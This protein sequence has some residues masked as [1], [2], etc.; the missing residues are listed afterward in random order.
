[1]LPSFKADGGKVGNGDAAEI[2]ILHGVVLK[3]RGIYL[4]L[5]ASFFPLLFINY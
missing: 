3:I 5:L 2:L 4:L 1:M